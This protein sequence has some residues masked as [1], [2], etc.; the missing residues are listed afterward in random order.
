MKRVVMQAVGSTDPGTLL[1]AEHVRLSS[2]DRVLVLSAGD[3]ALILNAGRRAASV[4][5]YDISYSAIQRAQEQAAARLPDAPITFSDDVFPDAESNL[6]VALMTVPKG[7]DFARAQLWSALKALRPGGRLYIAG[8]TQGGAKSILDDTAVLFGHSVTLNTK[9]RY[10]IGVAVRPQLSEPPDYPTEWGADPTVVQR[11]TFETPCGPIPLATMPGIFSWEH[12]DD[13]TAFLMEHA[14]FEPGQAVLD[15]GSGNGVLGIAAA[16]AANS[17]GHV[18]LIDD[19][20][21]AVRCARS[22]VAINGLSNVTVQA[23]DVYSSLDGQQFDLIVSNPPFHK[24]FDVNTNVAHRVMREAKGHLRPGGRLVIVANAFLK[25]E[26]VMAAH[27]PKARV[28]ARNNRYI[29]IEG[30]RG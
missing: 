30:R 26:D 4:A 20:L 6:D 24:E 22:S 7:R 19:N 23:A 3:P 21:L 14:A 17:T 27:L 13:G 10:R 18:T 9:R 29:V 28:L 12:L 1:L 2:E 11:R 15:V 5:V 25:Y 8:P 16:L